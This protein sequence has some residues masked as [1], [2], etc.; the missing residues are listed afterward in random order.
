MSEDKLLQAEILELLAQEYDKNPHQNIRKE[1]LLENLDLKSNELEGLILR[2]ESKGIVKLT[3]YIG[4]WYVRLSPIGYEYYIDLLEKTEKESSTQI[5]QQTLVPIKKELQFFADELE[6]LKKSQDYAKAISVKAKLQD[7]LRTLEL[8]TTDLRILQNALDDLARCLAHMIH[9]DKYDEKSSNEIYKAF[10]NL[11]Y[12]LSLF[13]KSPIPLR[14][15]STTTQIQSYQ[16]DV[17]KS[18]LGIKTHSKRYDVF[19][20]HASEDKK[21][22]ADPLAE[23]LRDLGLVVWYDKFSLGW[24]DKLMKKIN[25]GI[26]NSKLGIIIFSHK[27]FEK[28]WAQ[29]ELD[30]LVERLNLDERELLPL[31]YN[32]SV[33]ELKEYL[34]ILSGILSR[35]WE[36]GI[37]NLSK[38]ILEIVN[39]PNEVITETSQIKI[40]D[41]DKKMLKNEIYIP[42]YNKMKKFDADPSN[43]LEIPPNPWLD[44][45]PYQILK[46]EKDIKDLFAEY[47]VEL[48]KWKKMFIEIDGGFE[49][50]KRVLGN[51]IAPAFMKAGLLNER[52]MIILDESSSQEPQHWIDAFKV[53]IFDNTI[54]D[55]KTLLKKLDEHC[56]RT[57][58]GMK[59]YLLYWEQHYPQIFDLIAES[60]PELWKK[61]RIEKVTHSE[62]AQQRELLSKK[63][64]DIVSALEEKVKN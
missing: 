41:E 21:L 1:S 59:R 51:L 44:L 5:G 8:T 43:L 45:E 52:G 3:R 49:T 36:D 12:N 20:C 58:S 13:I 2:L 7:H 47:K 54:T 15:K 30:G 37:D 62:L 57:N 9:Y 24:G 64:S 22:V 16:K 14:K 17:V 55:G 39:P 34:P 35:S 50:N 4:G 19:I 25:E 32:L 56:A 33:E 18:P 31:R 23:K 6:K 61:L 40:S 27:F 48:E 26:L 38:E 60:L 53:I 10:E 29:L 63:I 28:K 46:V 11:N 42:L